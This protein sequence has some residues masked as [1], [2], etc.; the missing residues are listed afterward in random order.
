MTDTEFAGLLN[1]K[2][3][4]E[5]STTTTT[6]EPLLGATTSP[7]KGTKTFNTTGLPTEW[8][9]RNKSGVTPVKNQGSCG[10]CWAFAANCALESLYLIKKGMNVSLSQ[11]QLVDCSGGYGN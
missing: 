4:K 7:N 3:S 6:T 8:D 5:P 2:L 9:W 10:S 1:A 11:Q